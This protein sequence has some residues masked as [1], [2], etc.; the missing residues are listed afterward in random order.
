[1]EDPV[2]RILLSDDELLR[3]IAEN[4]DGMS[5]LVHEQVELEAGIG[6]WDDPGVRNIL[7][8]SNAQKIGKLERQYH[9]FAA[10]LRR[11]CQ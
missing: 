10:E 6:E 9:D 4:T 3:A 1:V 11:R 2:Q 5:A 7:M 8:R